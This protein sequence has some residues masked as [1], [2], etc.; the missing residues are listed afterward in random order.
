MHTDSH[1]ISIQKDTGKY[2][3]YN[4]IAISCYNINFINNLF[5]VID[6]ALARLYLSD[7]ANVFIR[8]L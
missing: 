8:T 3:S 2:I 7:I 6:Q 4:D 5:Y 1:L